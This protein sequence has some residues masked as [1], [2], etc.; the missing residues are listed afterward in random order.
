MATVS[1]LIEILKDTA[2]R[3]KSGATYRWTHQGRCNCG[4]LA[5]TITGL[6]PDDI[7]QIALTGEGEW[8]DHAQT[9]CESSG[10][11]VDD[12]ITQLLNAGLTI[13][14][15]GHLEWLSDPKVLRWVPT[16]QLPLDYKRRTDVV[17]YF[18]TWAKV[19]AAEEELRRNPAAN[20]E[21]NGRQYVRR[22]RAETALDENPVSGRAA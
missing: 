4:H 2:K 6:S 12:L 16:T 17:A 15:L 10:L 1:R 7:H 3:L 9:F 11:A 8:R 21:L 20:V 22:F 19:L 13:E 5:Q 18:E 14:D